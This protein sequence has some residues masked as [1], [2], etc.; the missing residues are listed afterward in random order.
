ML[1]SKLLSY[2]TL[3]SLL[4]LT[5]LATLTA[6]QSELEFP[7]ARLFLGLINFALMWKDLISLFRV[8]MEFLTDRLG[9]KLNVNDDR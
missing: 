9:Y 7:G 3:R 8:R 4:I 6:F 5:S 1:I 2:I